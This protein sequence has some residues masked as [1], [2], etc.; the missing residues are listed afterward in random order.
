M[1]CRFI[2]EDGEKTTEPFTDFYVEWSFNGFTGYEEAFS[3]ELDKENSKHLYVTANEDAEEGRMWI[4]A[5]YMHRNEDGSRRNRNPKT[6]STVEESYM[7]VCIDKRPYRQLQK[8][9]DGKLYYYVDGKSDTK[10]EG[11]MRF[12]RSMIIMSRWNC[13]NRYKWSAFCSGRI[14]GG[15]VRRE[16]IF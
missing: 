6:K 3:I 1:Q 11:T 16:S 10:Y 5:R 9:K 12:G 13:C 2:S 14:Q 8:G 15:N 4:H 7:T